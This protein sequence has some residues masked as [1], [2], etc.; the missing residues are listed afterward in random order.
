[1]LLIIEVEG[2]SLGKFLWPL[3]GASNQMLAALTL[4]ILSIYFWE[5]RKNIL[6]LVIPML[7][8]MI[9][10][11]SALFIKFQES[12]NN[13]VLFINGTLIFLIFWMI[14]EGIIHIKNNFKNG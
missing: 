5:K 12:T 2:V 3:F 6:P 13:M 1:M 9:I 14:I 11:I 7:L 8:I 10:T 4:M